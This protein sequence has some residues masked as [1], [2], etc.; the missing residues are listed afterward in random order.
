MLI[1]NYSAKEICDFLLL[2]VFLL[3]T[4]LFFI[5][6]EKFCQKMRIEKSQLNGMMMASELL[7]EKEQ[8]FMRKLYR[9]LFEERSI[10]EKLIL[11]NPKTSEE[12][13]KDTAISGDGETDL[14]TLESLED[15][16][17]YDHEDSST[18]DSDNEELEDLKTM[19]KKECGELTEFKDVVQRQS[20]DFIDE[21]HEGYVIISNNQHCLYTIQEEYCL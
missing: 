2:S 3:T 17:E 10:L 8:D 7:Y 12:T 15:V 21:V 20:Q 6:T 5:Y 18:D 14:S 4:L 11:S 13:N 9:F 16:T 1:N 19:Q